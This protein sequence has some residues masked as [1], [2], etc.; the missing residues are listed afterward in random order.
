MVRPASS[1]QHLAKSR[2]LIIAAALS[3][4]MGNGAP[5]WLKQKK[6]RDSPDAG[7]PPRRFLLICGFNKETG[8][9]IDWR[10]FLFHQE[11]LRPAKRCM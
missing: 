1:S 9:T 6:L 8:I 11:G 4:A 5:E 10:P 7:K 3:Y 2:V